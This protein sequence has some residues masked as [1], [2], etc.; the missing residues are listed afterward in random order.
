MSSIDD[1]RSTLERHAD[2]VA[3]HDLHVRP[4]AVRERVRAVRRRRRSALAVG[5]VAVIGAAALATSLEGPDRPDPAGPPTLAG[6]TAPAT[7]ASLGYTYAFAAGTEGDG[8]ARLHLQPSGQPTLVSWATAGD[9]EVTL[10]VEGEKPRLVTAD[11]FG[12]FTFLAPGDGAT[13]TVTGTGEVALAA[14]TLT[15][16]PPPGDTRDG[17]TFRDEA[18]GQRLLTD[19]IGDPGDA[20]LG[21]SVDLGRGPLSVST[22]CSGG[23]RGSWV[24]VSVDNGDTVSGQGC[25]DPLFDP[26]ARG[27]FTPYPDTA[28]RGNVDLRIWVT[29]GEDGPVVDDPDVRL[30]VGAYSPAPTVRRLAGSSLTSTEEYDGHTWRLVDVTSSD[31][32]DRELV[33][34]TVDGGD[35]LVRLCFT[36]TGTGAVQVITNGRP[37]GSSFGSDAGGSTLELLQAARG[38]LGLRVGDDVP[39]GVELGLARYVRVD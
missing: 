24:H 5:V 26:A 6:H 8:R 22:L 10:R 14:Y 23:P 1:L 21:L 34:A 36:G 25:D 28:G 18:V 27:G 39:P 3:D 33:V 19:V 20:D 9:D 29:A 4:V 12:D 17:I 38:T 37:S 31:P 11:D 16:P 32:G 30:A 35:T 13:V 7:M 2:G 15:D